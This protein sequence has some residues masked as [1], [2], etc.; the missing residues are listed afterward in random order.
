MGL[1]PRTILVMFGEN[2]NELD[3]PAVTD[4]FIADGGTSIRQVVQVLE[5][6]EATHAH[7]WSFISWDPQ[8][9]EKREV[10]DWVIIERRLAVCSCGR[11]VVAE[12]RGLL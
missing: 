4:E 8:F 2:P 3:I 11:K 12:E 1:T 7:K 6:G 9:G 10:T 5:E